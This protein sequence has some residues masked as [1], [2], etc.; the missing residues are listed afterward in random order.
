MLNGG[1]ALPSRKTI[2]NTMIPNLYNQIYEKVQILM[3]NCFAV[4]LTIDCWTSVKNESFMGIT[5]HFINDE[6]LLQSVCLCCEM[7]D[8]RHTI[9]NLATYLK[10]IIQQWHIEHKITAIVSDNAPNI[11]GA[12]KKCN[13][14]HI[15]CFA[16]SIN[17]VVQSGLKVISVVHKKVKSI[18]EYFKRS[19]HAQSKLQEIQKQMGLPPL[20]LKQDIITRWN[21][22]QDMFQHIIQIKDSV[23]STMALLQCDEEQL[24]LQE[25]QIVESASEVL[26]IFSEITKEVS[27]EKYVSMSKVLIFIKVMV[28]T[29]ETFEKNTNLPNNTK[30]MVTTLLEKLNARFKHYEDNDIITQA[31]LLDPRFKKLAFDGYH[32]R[33]LEIA[34]EHLKKKVCQVPITETENPIDLSKTTNITN[35]STSLIWKTFDNRYLQNNLTVIPTAAGIIELGKYMQ[36]PLISRHEDPLKWWMAHKLLYPQ[37]FFLVKK[38]LCILA[39]SVPCERLFSKA[40]LVIT[41]RR[42]R[43]LASKSS[44]VLFINQNL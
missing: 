18:V 29:M 17:L 44:Q 26:Q 15:P 42:N 35:D 28:G 30:Q 25:W 40:S 1:Y 33:K 32:V 23:I 11:V 39:T 7:F 2:S 38:R 34:M 41:E 5:A 13:Y 14:R 19:S 31:A 6:G 9:D 36:E 37:L 4:C 24:T 22:T 10:N 43:M 20:K 27:S 16:H 8:D 12:I 21:S 3:T